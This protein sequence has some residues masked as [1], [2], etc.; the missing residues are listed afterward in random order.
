MR[1]GQIAETGTHDQLATQED[2]IY[3]N[4]VRLQ[5]EIIE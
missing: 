5:F 3:A 1:E 2:G 4:L